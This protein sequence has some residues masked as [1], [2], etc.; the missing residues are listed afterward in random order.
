MTSSQKIRLVTAGSRSTEAHALEEL[1]QQQTDIV[2]VAH[3]PEIMNV[4]ELAWKHSPH[5]ILLHLRGTQFALE[6]LDELLTRLPDAKLLL[7]MPAFNATQAAHLLERGA[8]GVLAGALEFSQG[9]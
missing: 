6:V 2:V 8:R 1:L 5:V 3:C 7:V 9:I 4:A